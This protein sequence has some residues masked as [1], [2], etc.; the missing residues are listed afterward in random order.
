MT[1]LIRIISWSCCIAWSLSM[2]P[3]VRADVTYTDDDLT[4]IR[5]TVTPAAEPVPALKYRLL[6]R[7]IDLKSGNAASFYYRASMQLPRGMER[8]RKKFDEVE[9]LGKWYGTGADATPIAELPIDSVREACRFIDGLILDYL[10]DAVEQRQC[11][12]QLNVEDMRG[13]DVIAFL[14][15]EF[16]ESR[17]ISRMLALR[18]RFA[19]AEQRYGDAVDTMRINYRLAQD[20]AKLPFLVNGL[21]GIAEAGIAN[22]TM[23]ELIAQPNSPNLYWAIAELPVP[24]IDLRAA[25]R[26]EMDFGPRIFPLIQN[27][28][29]TVRAPEEWNRLF[30]QSIRDMATV[31]GGPSAFPATN[32]LSAGLVA[33]ATA[34]EGYS[35]AKARLIAKGMD[36]EKVKAMAVG[37][38]MAIYTERTYQRLADEYAKLCYMPFWEM[39]RRANAVD[40]ALRDARTDG[41]QPDREV[42]PVASILIPAWQSARTAQM[43]LERDLAALRLIEA[44][45]M[46]AASHAG[47]LPNTLDEITEVPVPLNP[48]TG[49]SFEYRLDGETAILNLPASDGISGYHRRFEIF[50]TKTK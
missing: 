29:T 47:G 25:A 27:A 19:I 18:T 12:W 24:L 14:L 6:A 8:L 1:Q 13:V 45:R 10:S 11:N 33:T 39:R 4:I 15:P 21:I 30:T 49:Q 3:D 23:I 31:G 41:D 50:I 9:Q 43:R 32:D 20:V 35:H 7:D 22:E 2:L 26:L 34:L 37:Q 28:E 44:L 40:D 46:Y 36:P 42:L 48:A 38:A 16:Q 5:M 17:E